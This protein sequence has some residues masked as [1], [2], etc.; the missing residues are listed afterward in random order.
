MCVRAWRGGGEG[1]CASFQRQLQ[2]WKVQSWELVVLDIIV[3]TLSVY[4][5]LL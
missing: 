5:L 3:V 1:A 4:G 2:E